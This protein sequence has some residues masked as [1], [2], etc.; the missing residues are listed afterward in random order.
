MKYNYFFKARCK[1]NILFIALFRTR[2]QYLE[3]CSRFVKAT[4]ARL[5]EIKL[6]KAY[7]MEEVL[8]LENQRNRKKRRPSKIDQTRQ[9]P[10]E[11]LKEHRGKSRN[12]HKKKL[13][14]EFPELQKVEERF[15]EIFEK[16][17]SKH[18]N[19]DSCDIFFA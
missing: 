4:D 3:R 12:M 15:F 16:V 5:K 11:K 1:V 17:I 7:I 13:K 18:I 14:D 8:S 2:C 6:T 10:S 9:E 19:V